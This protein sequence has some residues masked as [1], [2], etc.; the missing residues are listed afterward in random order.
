[1]TETAQPDL[2]VV[3]WMREYRASHPDACIHETVDAYLGEPADPSAFPILVASAR[4]ARKPLTVAGIP[5][6][7]GPASLFLATVGTRDGGITAS[8]GVGGGELWLW[9]KDG[10][11]TLLM[12]ERAPSPTSRAD[13]VARWDHLAATL[14]HVTTEETH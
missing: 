14:P 3:A 2:R 11:G 9:F 7:Q 6:G 5:A 10:D 13:F 8:P 12:L 1:M 4:A